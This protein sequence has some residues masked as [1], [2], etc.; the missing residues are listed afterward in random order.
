MRIH[1]IDIVQPPG[2]AIQPDIE[3]QRTAVP[4][5][6]PVN[7]IA[8]AAKNARSLDVVPVEL[9]PANIVTAAFVPCLSSVPVVVAHPRLRE[10]QAI[11]VASLRNDVEVVTVSYTHLTLPTKRIV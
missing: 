1:T 4:A 3:R 11:L 6:Q 10:R 9:P 7:R 5:A 2:M 8:A